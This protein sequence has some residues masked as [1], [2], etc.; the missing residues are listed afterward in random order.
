MGSTAR[1]GYLVA[2]ACCCA[3]LGACGQSS[4]K[5]RDETAARIPL[6]APRVVLTADDR[7]VWAPAPP[8]RAVVPVLLYHGVAPASG[9]SKRTDAD[10]GIDPEDFARQMALLDHAGYD[11][12][13]LGEF[14]RFIR[15]EQVSLPPR[16]LLLTFE[17]RAP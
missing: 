3:A 16:P 17:R 12:I 4:D 13:T 11:T 14:V 10:L 7:E 15:R 2:A 5:S 9:F 1:P 8:D 6:P